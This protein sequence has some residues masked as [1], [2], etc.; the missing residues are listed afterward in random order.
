MKLCDEVINSLNVAYNALF[1]TPCCSPSGQPLTVVVNTM[2]MQMYLYMAWLIAMRQAKRNDLANYAKYQENVD[3]VIYGD[4]LIQSVNPS[5]AKIY[6]NVILSTILIDN[7]VKYTDI[8]KKPV[9]VPFR[10]LQE[11]TF[12]GRNFSTLNGTPVGA[13]DEDMIRDIINWTKC[14]TQKNLLG[15]MMSTTH[16]VL[17]EAMFLGRRKHAEFHSKLADWW[18]VKGET[19]HEHTFDVLQEK[20]K[21]DGLQESHMLTFDCVGEHKT[22]AELDERNL[23]T[24]LDDVAGCTSGGTSVTQNRTV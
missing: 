19:L 11:V 18:S 1:E 5:I 15:H 16:G 10:R 12:L 14:R 3:T 8:D 13:L 7:G 9:T 22:I 6:N 17:I 21:R 2:C 24:S 4:D 23:E 20:W